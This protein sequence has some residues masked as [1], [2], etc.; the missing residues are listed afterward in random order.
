[1]IEAMGKDFV[2]TARASGLPELTILFRHALR[3]AAIPILT[4]SGLLFQWTLAGSVLV[5]LIFAWPGVGRYAVRSSLFLDYNPLLAVI[6]AF[7]LSCTAVNLIVD[8]LYGLFD[9]RVRYQ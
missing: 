7:G 3:Y 8:V 6:L 1:M 2:L 4:I 5:E 9:P